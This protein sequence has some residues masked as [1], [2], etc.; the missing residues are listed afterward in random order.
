MLYTF[1]KSKP[2]DAEFDSSIRDIMATLKNNIKEEEQDNLPK[3]EKALGSEA[4]S[5]LANS[6][7]RSKKFLPTRSHPSAPDKGPLMEAIGILTAPFDKLQDM[8]RKFPGAESG[9]SV[10]HQPRAAGE[11]KSDISPFK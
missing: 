10:P 9:E 1:Q 5:V 6:F 2:V 8:F 7:E 4:S 3:L 11:K